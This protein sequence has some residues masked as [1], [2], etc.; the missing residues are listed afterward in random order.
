[1]ANVTGFIATDERERPV[2]M[3]G[4]VRSD[5]VADAAELISMWVDPAARGAGAGDALVQA[6][7]DRARRMG[8]GRLILHVVEGNASAVKLYERNGFRHTGEQITRER[9]G[10]VELE[11]AL[12]FTA[13]G[14]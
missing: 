11:M 9:D 3:A 13:A 5:E 1:L 8:V 2:G 4:V 14:A 7:V 6:A 12:E 10:A